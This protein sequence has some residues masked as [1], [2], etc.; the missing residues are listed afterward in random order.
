MAIDY[1]AKYYD[2]YS[3]EYFS[4]GKAEDVPYFKKQLRQGDMLPAIYYILGGVSYE[5]KEE[6]YFAACDT[7]D[8]QIE[9]LKKLPRRPHKVINIGGGRGEIDAVLRLL[10][11]D[12]VCV[13]PSP[14]AVVMYAQTMEKWANTHNYKFINK[15][16]KDSIN[17]NDVG[18]DFDTLVFCESIEHIPE[19][20]FE[21]V[22]PIVRSIL[23]KNRGLL[24]VTN[25]MGYHP[26]YPNTWDHVRIIDD[27]FY[28]YLSIEAKKVI[29]R[30]G[31]HLVLQF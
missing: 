27:K 23:K 19:D 8:K 14:G 11:I 4:A 3:V 22:W 30:R 31:S 2:R 29:F 15:R 21:S 10:N 1:S 25:W 7:L 20:E 18:D 13:D 5:A 17:D 9:M 12:C 24:I 6:I 26:L 16:Y 28:D